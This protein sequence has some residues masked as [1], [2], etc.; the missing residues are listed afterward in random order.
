MEADKRNRMAEETAKLYEMHKNDDVNGMINLL[1]EL[2]VTYSGD[3]EKERRDNQHSFAMG[4]YAGIFNMFQRLIY[5]KKKEL[6]LKKQIKEYGIFHDMGC[7]R[8]LGLIESDPGITFEQI[9]KITRFNRDILE[10]VMRILVDVG[11]VKHHLVDLT[12]YF[13]ISPFGEKLIFDMT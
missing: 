11:I 2:D 10:E 5:D 7:L 1:N 6:E 9:R 13:E 3:I 4:W 12:E 8:I